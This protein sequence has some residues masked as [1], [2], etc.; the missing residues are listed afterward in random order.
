MSTKRIFVLLAFLAIAPLAKA[1]L[2]FYSGDSISFPKEVINVLNRIDT[3]SARKVAY[4]FRSVW[5]YEI[6]NEQRSLVLRIS[7]KMVERRLQVRPYHEYFFGYLTYAVKQKG[8]NEYQLTKVLT[9]TKEAAYNY[10][11][12]E[13]RK[14]LLSLNLYFAR[15]YLYWGRDNY[16]K[17]V[18][19]VYTFESIGEITSSDASFTAEEFVAEETQIDTSEFVTDQEV[20][21]FGSD[22]QSS[23]DWANDPWG[24]DQSSDDWANDPW[25]ND[26]SSD[27]WANDPWGNNDQTDDVW[28]NNDQ[29][30]D[31]WGNSSNDD[32][33]NNDPWAND[34]WGN[35]QQQTSNEP[36]RETFTPAI[37]D[38]VYEAKSK[39][40]E[41]QLTGPV[42]NLDSTDIVMVTD[43]DSMIIEGTSGQYELKGHA[44]VGNGGKSY[45]PG[46]LKVMRGAEIEF[47]KYYFEVDEAE[48]WTPNAT[49]TFPDFFEGEAQGLYRFKSVRT[50]R[51]KDKPFPY[52]ESYN[53]DLVVNLPF[54]KVKYT[55][56]LAFQ[57]NKMYGKA[58]SREKGTLEIVDGKGRKL[59]AKSVAFSFVDSLITSLDAEVTIVH[60]SD[61]ITH[62]SVKLKYDPATYL[63]ELDKSVGNYKNSAFQSSFY[64]M[65]FH[66]DEIVWDMSTDSLNISINSARNLIPTVFISDD[67]FSASRFRKYGSGLG[68]H[69]V[70][71]CVNYANKYNARTF[72]IDEI[73][74]EHKITESQ[75][76]E[77]AN[78]LSKHGYATYNREQRQLTLL[79]QAYQDYRANY[80]KSDYDHLLIASLIDSSPNATVNFNDDLLTIRGIDEFY[81]SEDRDLRIE[82]DSG[83][84]V[85]GRNR[86]LE[87]DGL[88]NAGDFQYTGRGFTFDYDQFLISMPTI[89]SITIQVTFPDSLQDNSREPAEK[90]QLG[91]HIM[92]TSGTLFLNEPQNK[93][94]LSEKAS[95]P[96]F[97]SDSEA[98]VYFDSPEYLDGAYDKSIKFIV[99]P[100]EMDSVNKDDVGGIVFQGRL[101][102]GIFP[103]FEEELV[104][105]PDKTLGFTHDVPQEGYNLYNSGAKI[106]DHINLDGNG[107]RTSGQLDYL[108]TSIHSGDFVFYMDSVTAY[109]T[110]GKIEPGNYQ[111]ASYPQARL[112]AFSMKWLPKKDSMYIAN[113]GEAFSFYNNTAT[114][115]GEA[116]VTKLGVF[117]SGTMLTRGSRSFSD[118][119]SFSEFEYSARH[120]DFEVLTDDP[121]KPAMAGDDISLRFDLIQ[122]SADISPENSGVAAISFPYAQMKTS[123]TEAFWDLA[124][125]VV[126]MRKPATVDIEDSYFYSTRTELDSLVFNAEEA[127]YDINTYELDI[128][129]IPYII[130]ADAK[131]TPSNGETTIL[132]N[133]EL[134][135]FEDATVVIDTLNGYHRLF[136]ANIKILSRNKFEG[137]G[138]YELTT[139]ALDTFEI[140][141]NSFELKNVKIDSKE[142]RLMT[143]SGG[144]IVE[145]N[146]VEVSAGFLYRGSATMYAYKKPLELD[147]Y[148]KLLL[149]SFGNDYDRWVVYERTDASVDEVVIDFD[150]SQFEEGDEL[151]AGLHYSIRGDIYPTFISDKKDYGDHDLFTPSGEIRFDVE[152][153]YYI[154]ETPGKTAGEQYAGSTFIYDDATQDVIFEGPFNFSHATEKGYSISS[155][156]LGNGNAKDEQF[157]M[158][159]FITLDF[160]I[161]LSI[162]DEMSFD[163]TDL[164]ERIGSSVA[165]DNSIELMYNLANLIGE[166]ATR[167]YEEKGLKTYIPL[168]ETSEELLK[169]F[170]FSNVHLKWDKDNRVWYNTSKIG[171]SNVR[172]TDIN[173]SMN[174]FMEI[175]QNDSGLDLINIFLQPA[176]GTWYFIGYEDHHLFLISSNPDFNAD[177]EAKSNNGTA[178]PGELVLLTAEINEVLGF[179]NNFRSNHMGID[180]PY[181]L[182]LPDDIQLEDDENFDTIEEEDDDDDGFGF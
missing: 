38:Y 101:V 133:S 107:I 137:F 82:P 10:N 156:V 57:G 98:V 114:L 63:L 145:S 75:A 136:D 12:E 96:Y 139:A 99:P 5:D 91:N 64:K 7:E 69:P 20:Q 47:G 87:F 176:A 104:I 40:L 106:Y 68:F 165:H 84:L 26:Q 132:E 135:P 31:V 151:I 49:I 95:Y 173:A 140:K 30:D 172:S 109:G 86:L 56:G 175:S 76:L 146:N 110:H 181:N 4:D 102:S 138:T 159:A 115:D 51:K 6:T 182:E 77:M 178:K 126:T 120:A 123:I 170:V 1:Q 54:D 13:L 112:G 32:W 70:I 148:V 17:A 61:S 34:P 152:N 53:A 130:V 44:F 127:V 180:D 171:L 153:Q 73:I 8:I 41:P 103:E 105:M 59:I 62:P 92:N 85:L 94:G 141:F 129:G 58:I 168:N 29:T 22:D 67:Y 131:I 161:P 2:F 121:E 35:S 78:M 3:E 43:I 154:I 45:W 21:S 134:T 37:K 72:Y 142:K 42:L 50:R 88:I 71:V 93:S 149:K 119:L 18:G 167:E 9:I 100:F 144:E 27:D 179:I 97:V 15:E 11:N 116:N 16:T 118:E 122:N 177:I 124:D 55:G 147:G 143:V 157:E 60:G 155:T 80:R 174:G 79:D 14:F 108:T 158:D 81:L 90:E 65:S 169:T 166:E 117:G 23:D 164:I 162:T 52:F 125:S 24:N 48:L 89:D 25:G 66:T 46:E 160:G 74:N 28:G 36:Q 83:V 33:A 150:N 111:G 113:I 128:K 19:G 163:L 39:Y